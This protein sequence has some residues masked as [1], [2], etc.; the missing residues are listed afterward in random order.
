MTINLAL[1]IAILM[2]TFCCC[3]IWAVIKQ[4]FQGNPEYEEFL[5]DMG[6]TDEEFR[7]KFRNL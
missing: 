2:I 6:L 1:P 3:I 4:L 5:R 7:E